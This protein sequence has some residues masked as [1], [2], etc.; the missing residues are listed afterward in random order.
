MTGE[1]RFDTWYLVALAGAV[2]LGAV[3]PVL[4]T[5]AAV[6]AGAVLASHHNPIGLVGVLLAGAIGAYVGD[7]VVYAVCR[8]GGERMARRFGWLRANASLEAL[9]VRLADHEVSVLLTSRLLPGGRVPV[10]LSAGLA[11]FSWRRFAVVDLTASLLW[12]AVYM[13]IGL[14][15]FA[16][17]DEP[18]QGVLAAIV[19]VIAVSVLSSLVRSRIRRRTGPGSDLVA[20]PVADPGLSPRP[21]PGPGAVS[22]AE[23]RVS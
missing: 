3:L 21:E 23:G 9:R 19:L 22:D 16:L 17:F 15:G 12:A 4:P 8:F 18:W 2:F 11:G 20:D 1:P 5:G 14:L 13:A 7:L 6:S 10:L